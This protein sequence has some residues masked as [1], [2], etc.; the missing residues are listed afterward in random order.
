MSTIR[1]SGFSHGGEGALDAARTL[2]ALVDATDAKPPA[3][4][5][6]YETS[7]TIPEKIRK[8]ARTVYGADDI[9]I[10]GAAAK[11]IER[12][13]AQGHGGL[14]V[15]MAKTQLSLSDDPARVGRPKGFI[16]HVRELRVSAGA[17]FVVAITG[18]MM[19]MP[20]L[21]KEPAA[22][23]V[24]VEADGRIRGLM[25]NDDEPAPAIPTRARPQ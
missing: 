1:S 6:V 23:K 18:D 21:P 11:Q 22:L 17:G 14:P 24:R 13:V 20:G 15:C 9:S 8:I 4:R 7:D 3:P 10:S 25:Q 5:F 19:T 2:A 16:V 12:A